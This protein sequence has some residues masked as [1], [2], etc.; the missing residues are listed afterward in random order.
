MRDDH[1]AVVAAI[2]AE[3]EVRQNIDAELAVASRGITADLQ[4]SEQQ[5]E[6]LAQQQ[7]ELTARL[8]RLAGLR[9]RYGNLVDDLQQ[10]TQIVNEAKQSLAEARA[11]QG[12]AQASSL[13]TRFQAPV[14][15]ERPE[16]PGKRDIVAAGLVG[17]L[18]IGAGLVILGVPTRPSNGRRW[19]DFLPFG[20]RAADRLAAGPQESRTP[21]TSGR[22]AEDRVLVTGA[23]ATKALPVVEQRQSIG[24]RAIDSHTISTL[25]I[26]RSMEQ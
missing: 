9:A 14:A 1:P 10:S 24:R 5:L 23:E 22:R 12:A 6:T 25:D 13:L 19:T 26:S 2:R 3:E 15:G 20:R 7:G 16:G 4:V 8:H 21:A 11:S 17:G 18:L